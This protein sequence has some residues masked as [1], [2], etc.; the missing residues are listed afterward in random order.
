[1]TRIAGVDERMLEQLT[2]DDFRPYLN[3]KFHVTVDEADGALAVEL[4]EVS[5]LGEAGSGPRNQPFSLVFR[6][7]RGLFLPQQIYTVSHD[8]MGPI[9]IFL[10]PIRPDEKG[11]QLQA[12]FN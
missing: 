6:G 11:M 3:S 7:P 10:V 12:I 1:M 9:N 2:A 5:D 8:E 4:I